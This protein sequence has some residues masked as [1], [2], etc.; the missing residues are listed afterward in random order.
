MD[1]SL[2]VPLL[3]LPQLLASSSV[4]SSPMTTYHVTL[5]NT[6]NMA[7]VDQQFPQKR[8]TTGIGEDVETLE[9]LSIADSSRRITRLQSALKDSHQQRAV[10]MSMCIKQ[11]QRI[12]V[13]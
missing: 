10:W 13:E 5:L 4:Q 3:P 7:T 6:P 12:N 8:M 2:P 11:L 9:P 1:F